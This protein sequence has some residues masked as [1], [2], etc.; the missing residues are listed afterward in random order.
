MISAVHEDEKGRGIAP[1]ALTET[2]HGHV[3]GVCADVE[4]LFGESQ[5]GT[6]ELFGWVPEGSG[7]PAWAGSRVWLVP[8]DE[9]FDAWLLEDAESLGQ[10]PGT[11][12]LVLTGLDDY[13]GP[14]EGYRGRVRVH[15]GHRWL[16]SCREFTRIL[17]PDQMPAPIV[18]RGLAQSDQ[19]RAALTKGTRRALDLEEAALEIRD[20]RGELLTGGLDALGVQHAGAR[21][22]V[23]AF[24][25]SDQSPQNSVELVE[26]AVL[27]P[28]GEIAVD[29]LPWGEV[30]GQVPPGDPGAVDVEDGVHDS[31]KIV[32]GR[33]ADVQALPSSLG[34]PG[35]QNGL[36]NSHRASD[37]SLGYGRSRDMFPYYRRPPCCHRAQ[38]GV[39]GGSLGSDRSERLETDPRLP[40]PA[41]GITTVAR[42][43]NRPTQAGH[44]VRC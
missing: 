6:Y 13:E 33:P 17:S 34:P 44:P 5:R 36:L 2:E 12:S 38:T 26:D 28:G 1:Y 19:L 43:L 15:D 27:L 35:R 7:V 18:L 23:P 3:W 11:A 42:D 37:R 31:A 40:T 41:P 39:S 16:G 21:L 24:R 9:S 22:A 4:G 32:L 8:E 25:R 10:P 14:P 20:G 29:G 30:V